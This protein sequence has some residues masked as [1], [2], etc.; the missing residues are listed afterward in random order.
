MCRVH[1]IK[2]S[3]NKICCT[4]NNGGVEKKKIYTEVS[5]GYYTYWDLLKF[6]KD[7]ITIG[8]GTGVLAY[9]YLFLYTFIIKTMEGV[10][11]IYS[12]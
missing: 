3:S 5:L 8:E 4:L 12:I 9:E 7:Y 6:I 10:Y 11:E 2:M 1:H